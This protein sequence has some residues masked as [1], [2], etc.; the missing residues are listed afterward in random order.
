L[1]GPSKLEATVKDGR[2]VRADL[3]VVIELRVSRVV[4]QPAKIEG[5]ACPKDMANLMRK[6][7]PRVWTDGGHSDRRKAD[8]LL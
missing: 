3:P 8:A 2:H 5:M 6:G 7:A 4:H 1:R